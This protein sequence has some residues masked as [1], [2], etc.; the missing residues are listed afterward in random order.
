MQTKSPQEPVVYRE[1]AIASEFGS[2]FVDESHHTH[3]TQFEP[4]ESSFG[5]S[6]YRGPPMPWIPFILCNPW[7]VL[8]PNQSH[9]T[10]LL[11]KLPFPW[12][13]NN[14]LTSYRESNLELLLLYT[15]STRPH[16][17]RERKTENTSCEWFELNDVL[18]PLKFSCIHDHALIQD[19]RQL[20]TL[21]LE[22]EIRF[23]IQ[24]YRSCRHGGCYL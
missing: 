11:T 18:F 12:V 17:H 4:L 20:R 8:E 6:I 23:F 3:K 14:R 2:L 5:R 13:P 7:F 22:S 24:Q 16:K 1:R 15:Q 19:N 10:P 9:A 21:C